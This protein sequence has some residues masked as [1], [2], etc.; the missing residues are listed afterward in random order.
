MKHYKD[1]KTNEL[2][3]YELDGSQDSIIPEWLVPVPDE[4]VEEIR[5]SNQRRLFYGMP[6]D[7]QRRISYPPITEYLD[8]VVKGDE[9]QLAKYISDCLEVKRKFPKPGVAA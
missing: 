1:P 2:Y 7:E 4:Q 9:V 8:A 3:A 6:Y 5:A